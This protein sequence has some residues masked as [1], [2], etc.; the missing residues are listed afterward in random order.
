MNNSSPKQSKNPE[1]KH[2]TYKF[3]DKNFY[4]QFQTERRIK[5]PQCSND[6]KNI[7]CGATLIASRWAVTAAHCVCHKKKDDC[8]GFGCGQHIL[9]HIVLGEHNL[10]GIDAFDMNRF[11]LAHPRLCF[12]L[13]LF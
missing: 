10:T 11:V 8:N 9:T 5:C 7:A 3:Q 6:F 13:E 4:F 12:K 2:F 1:E